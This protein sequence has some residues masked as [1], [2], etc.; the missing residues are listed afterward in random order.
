MYERVQHAH[1]TILV[2]AKEV[3]SDLASNAENAFYTRDSECVDE[4]LRQSERYYL[5]GFESLTL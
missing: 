5:W 2:V 4:I 1:E 3:H